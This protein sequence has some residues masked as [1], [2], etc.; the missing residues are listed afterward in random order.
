VAFS[1]RVKCEFR[2]AFR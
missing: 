2:V 1:D